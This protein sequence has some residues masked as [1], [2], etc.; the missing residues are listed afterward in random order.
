MNSLAWVLLF[1][2]CTV[3]V[4]SYI[5]REKR[6]RILYMWQWDWLVRKIVEL[7]SR[8]PW[9]VYADVAVTLVVGPLLSWRF[10]KHRKQAVLA[11]FGYVL[12]TFVLLPALGGSFVGSSLLGAVFVTLFGFG[13]YALFLVGA[14]ACNIV[15]DY[16]S[17]GQPSPGIAPA[18]PGVRVGSVYIPFVEGVIA[19]IVAL[20]VH[21]GAHGVVAIRERIPVKS[22]GL[23]TL[24]L[25]P[26][27]AY[28]EPDEAVFR[29]A[30]ALS[31]A[32]VLS[33]GPVANLLV[34]ALFAALLVFATPLSNYLSTYACAVSS[35]VRIHDVPPTL[36]VGGG[37]IE[38]PAYG[39]LMPGD[40]IREINGNSVNC[41]TEFFKVLAPLREAE[42][43]VPLELKV[44]R[45][46]KE[47]N[48]VINTEKGYIGIVGVENAYGAPLP[49]WYR[50][51]ALLISILSWV[52]FLNLMIGLVN[53]LPL[54]PLDGGHIYKAIFEELGQ[55]CAY[56]LILWLTIAI[57]VVNV[58]PWFV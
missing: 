26:I 34:F 20:I 53:M 2:I 41:V 3:P 18:L 22:G 10:I 39:T 15:L 16:L 35:G 52:A 51:A 54:P 13:G 5:R 43:N 45:D 38:S 47:L 28:V 50:A 14:T 8:A 29:R 1:V 37:V 55:P 32:R 11:F 57:L 24:G 27:G 31:R 40:V 12:F 4:A 6:L 17:G 7:S 30:G 19:L 42:A 23:I 36:D 58:L 33:A 21:E 25:L 56:R 46:G 48:V 49:L 9:D 44:L